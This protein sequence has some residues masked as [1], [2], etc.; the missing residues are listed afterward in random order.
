[1]PDWRLSRYW[2]REIESDLPDCRV[3]YSDREQVVHRRLPMEFVYCAN[4]GVKAGMATTWTPHVFFICDA[5]FSK[6]G[7]QD[8]AGTIRIA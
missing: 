5:C 4:C 2:D 8:P 7:G 6:A 1:M 3:R